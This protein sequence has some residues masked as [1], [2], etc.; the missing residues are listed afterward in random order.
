MLVLSCNDN[1]EYNF[2]KVFIAHELWLEIGTKQV[3]VT[4]FFH[5]VPDMMMA[6]Y[7]IRVTSN[8]TIFMN[9]FYIFHSNVYRW[10]AHTFGGSV[11]QTN[12]HCL[13]Y[14]TQ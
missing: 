1:Q 10:L 2:F 11:F 14:L 8:L 12:I 6:T 3:P 7:D 4:S 9:C 5:S 13:F